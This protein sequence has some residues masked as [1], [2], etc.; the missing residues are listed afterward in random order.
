MRVFPMS[1]W[2]EL[3]VWR[4]V[5]REGIHVV[6]L[7]FAKERPVVERDGQLIMIDDDRY[8]LQRRRAAADAQR[9]VPH[10]RLLP[11]DGAVESDADDIDDL[12]AEMLVDRRS[13]RVRPAHRRRG[14]RLDGEQEDRG[15]LLMADRTD[16]PSGSTTRRS[17]STPSS[18]SS[19]AAPSTTAS[20]P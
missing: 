4:Y 17:P 9:A 16:A 11:A 5:Q 2:T 19:P 12:L 18:V 20:P 10:A 14:R 15:V 13:E 1:N 3:D 8:P 6:P 7:Y